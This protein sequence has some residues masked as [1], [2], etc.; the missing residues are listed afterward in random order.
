VRLQLFK[1]S[2]NNS[3]ILLQLHNGNSILFHQQWKLMKFAEAGKHE[4]RLILNCFGVDCGTQ[5][6]RRKNGEDW[7]IVGEK[8]EVLRRLRIQWCST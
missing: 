3:L 6:Q 2:N 1:S 7:E 4:S 8:L 5:L